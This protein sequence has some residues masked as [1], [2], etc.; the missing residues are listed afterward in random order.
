MKKNI[1]KEFLQKNYCGNCE[2]IAVILENFLNLLW[3][4]NQKINLISRKTPFNDYWTT[5]LLDSILPLP[6]LDFQKKKV[7]DF[8]TGGGFP[9]IPL[10]IL[11]PD[12]KMYLLDSKKK[13]IGVLKR[14]IKELDLKRCF[15]IVSR[16]EE[17]D[18]DWAG[19]FDF[20]VCRSVKIEEKFIKKMFKLLNSEGV[21]YLYKSKILDDLKF[22]KN[23]KIFDISHPE[24]GVR[25]L[26]K[27]EKI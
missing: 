14:I 23:Y 5:H 24:I 16:I 20:I 1:F 13:K 2:E 11:F 10:N 4:E 8:G 27:I 6:Y 17:M 12:S 25:K 26:I 19:N 21:I 7:L 15:T 22:F 18:D 3:E 9:G